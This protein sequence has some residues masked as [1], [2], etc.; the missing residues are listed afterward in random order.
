M[1]LLQLMAVPGGCKGR[2]DRR[3]LEMDRHK[4]RH[5]LCQ[6]IEDGDLL[7]DPPDVAPSTYGGGRA[8]GGKEPPEWDDVVLVLEKDGFPDPVYKGRRDYSLHFTCGAL[9]RDCPWTT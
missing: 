8:A 1:I 7:I 4:A 5:F 6:G 2:G 9:G 3:V